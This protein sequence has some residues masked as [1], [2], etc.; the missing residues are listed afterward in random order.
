MTYSK[1]VKNYI[2][3]LLNNENLMTSNLYLIFRQKKITKIN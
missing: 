2:K 1:Y 3:L